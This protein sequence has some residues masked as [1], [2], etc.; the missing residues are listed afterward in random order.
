MTEEQFLTIY[1]TFAL[2]YEKGAP[3][4]FEAEQ[5]EVA[6]MADIENEAW[7]TI[8]DIYDQYYKL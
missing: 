3:M 6:K 8:K 7:L 2:H 5:D 4:I 1:E